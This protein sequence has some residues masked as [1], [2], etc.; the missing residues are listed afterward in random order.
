MYEAEINPENICTGGRINISSLPVTV[1]STDGKVTVTI[2][3]VNLLKGNESVSFHVEKQKKAM[4]VG[5]G[6]SLSDTINKV[7]SSVDTKD[8]PYP[9]QESEGTIECPINTDKNYNLDEVFIQV[10]HSKN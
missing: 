4:N 7:G 6:C 8:F 2:T 5:V 1:I 10:S 9:I 3:S